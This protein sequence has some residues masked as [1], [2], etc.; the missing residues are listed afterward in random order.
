MLLDDE[1]DD[2]EDEDPDDEEDKSSESED[3]LDELLESS[4]YFPF[5]SMAMI[6]PNVMLVSERNERG[7]QRK[8][9]LDDR[10]YTIE[11]PSDPRHALPSL[12]PLGWFFF[13]PSPGL[14]RLVL[15]R[16]RWM[17]SRD[18]P[19]TAMQV[20]T[21]RDGEAPRESGRSDGHARTRLISLDIVRFYIQTLGIS[22]H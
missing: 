2:E 22:I 9:D 21:V 4:T 16:S 13:A 10:P 5:T 7:E 11:T 8:S 12:T 19:L 20:T 15:S 3:T 6:S 17:G 18:H 1:L 14:S